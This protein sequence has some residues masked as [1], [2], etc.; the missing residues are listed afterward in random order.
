M[1]TVDQTLRITGHGTVVASS[2]GTDTQSHIAP[3][4]CV[5]PSGRWLVSYRAARDK[6]NTL[7]RAMVTWSDDEGQTWSEPFAPFADRAV[8]GKIGQFRHMQC[9][10]LGGNRLVA[11]LWGVDAS[12][13]HKPFFNEKTE[14]I[15][16]SI[17]F[18]AKSDD[19]GAHWSE[20]T[21]G[22][23]APFDKFPCP[24]TGPI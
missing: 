7:Q 12:E 4:C 10:A 5:L 8:N 15:F 22:N 1:N 16:D 6:N 18:I 9:A 2:P 20:P 17:L 21:R 11:S 24:P 13:P 23:T 14:G 19:G 3:W